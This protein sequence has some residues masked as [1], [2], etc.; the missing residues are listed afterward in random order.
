MQS[1]YFLL[2]IALSMAPSQVYAQAVPRDPTLQLAPL[3]QELYRAQR[4]QRLWLA[5]GVGLL[6]SSLAHL[7]V[8]SA[9]G[10]NECNN[11]SHASVATAGVF[12][13][14]GLAF[15]LGG[16]I[17]LAHST[18]RSPATRAQKVGAVFTA[19][20]VAAGAQALLMGLWLV[21]GAGACSS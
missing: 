18:P 1:R 16:G 9:H 4:R 8:L 14:V 3:D 20:G 7:A 15:T 12:G 6:A 5:A 10:N 21:Q 11:D 17:R 13:G 2:W 19:L